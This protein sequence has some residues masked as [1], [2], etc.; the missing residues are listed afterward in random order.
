LAVVRFSVSGPPPSHNPRVGT[1][2]G[3]WRR[4]LTRSAK[5]QVPSAHVSG[6]CSVSVDFYLLPHTPVDIDAPL[7]ALLNALKPGGGRPDRADLIDD[8]ADVRELIARKHIITAADQ[9]HTEIEIHS[10]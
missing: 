7:E 9:E 8:D 1:P 2:V 4:Q 3:Q 5:Q 6:P 10:L